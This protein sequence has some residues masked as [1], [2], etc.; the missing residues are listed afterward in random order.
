MKHKLLFTKAANLDITESILWYNQQQAVLGDR[1]FSELSSKLEKIT[2]QPT[3]YPKRHNDIRC[4]KID[5]FPYLIHFLTEPQNKHL[6]VIAVL[7]TSL[8]PE[9]WKGRDVNK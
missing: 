4:G 8:N 7:H 1:F 6:I 2:I 5:H 9:L 3:S